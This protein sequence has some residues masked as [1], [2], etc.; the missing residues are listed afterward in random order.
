MLIKAD[1]RVWRSNSRFIPRPDCWNR[2]QRKGGLGMPDF[3][4]LNGRSGEIR[5]VAKNVPPQLQPNAAS[6][7]WSNFN[8]CNVR[9][10][11]IYTK[12][13]EGLLGAQ[14]NSCC[15]L[16]GWLQ[17]AEGRHSL[18]LHTKLDKSKKADVQSAYPVCPMC[19]R[20]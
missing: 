15:T 11:V 13:S 16:H 1:I 14:F 19:K 9:V 7:T 4:P 10:A 6:A 12:C 5:C 2:S 18:R 8:V 3:E 17:M 20:S